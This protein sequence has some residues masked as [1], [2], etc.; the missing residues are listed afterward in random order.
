MLEVVDERQKRGTV[1]RTFQAVARRFEVDHALLADGGE[2][3]AAKTIRDTFRSVETEV[4]ESLKNVEEEDYRK[5]IFM[6]LRCKGSPERIRQMQESLNA[7]L[8]EA[9]EDDE[10]DEF[11]EVGALIAFYPA[12]GQGIALSRRN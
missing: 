3:T 7:W 1:E 6:R 2:D 12:A 5:A 9:Q 10:G 4:I 8:E 11:E